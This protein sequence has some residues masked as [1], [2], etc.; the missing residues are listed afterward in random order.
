MVDFNLTSSTLIPQ[1]LKVI[2]KKQIVL[3]FVPQ[4]WRGNKLN[5]S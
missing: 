1:Y 3:L 2:H 4:V 5:K